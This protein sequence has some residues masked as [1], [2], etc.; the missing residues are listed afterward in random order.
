MCDLEE[1]K[2]VDQSRFDGVNDG[3]LLSPVMHAYDV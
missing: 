3:T 2:D 1:A